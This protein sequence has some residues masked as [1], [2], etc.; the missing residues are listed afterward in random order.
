[1]NAFVASQAGREA[2]QALVEMNSP[3]VWSVCRRYRPSLQV[4]LGTGSWVLGE[5]SMETL[6]EVHQIT[7]L[8]RF[9][10]WSVHIFFPVIIFQA[11]RK[12]G[13]SLQEVDLV[14]EATIGLIRAAE[15]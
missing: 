6:L 2:R 5:S 8:L 4:Y 11:A 9:Q 15:L 14:Q 12:A 1:M 3:L 13:G 7:G 10:S